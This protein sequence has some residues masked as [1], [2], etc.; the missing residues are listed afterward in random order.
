MSPSQGSLRTNEDISVRINFKGNEE[1]VDKT[2]KF[3]VQAHASTSE[4]A[5]E[6]NWSN[7]NVQNTKISLSFVRDFRDSVY[8]DTRVSLDTSARFSADMSTDLYEDVEKHK[9]ELMTESKS[10][11]STLDKIK[12]EIEKAKHRLNFSKDLESLHKAHTSKN[13]SYTH[14]LVGA[15]VGFLIGA[16]FMN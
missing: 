7:P 11:T 8:G 6:I 3:L 9:N 2:H 15:L 10:L 13:Y 4:N 5:S 12:T 14:L 16:F 1:S